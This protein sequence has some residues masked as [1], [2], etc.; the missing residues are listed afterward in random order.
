MTIQPQLID[1]CIKRDRRAEYELY[2]LTY[3]YLMSICMRYS[4]DKD[5]ASESLNIGFL[6][7]LKILPNC[8]EMELKRKKHFFEQEFYL[9]YKLQNQP[10][11]CKFIKFVDGH[12]IGKI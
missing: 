11:V 9:M 1:L 4:K 8:T 6:K 2:K 12:Q 3:S 5:A 7:I 10:N